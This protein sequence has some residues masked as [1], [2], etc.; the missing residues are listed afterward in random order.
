[1]VCQFTEGGNPEVMQVIDVYIQEIAAE[2]P[3]IL[4]RAYLGIKPW[5]SAD[6]KQRDA[7]LHSSDFDSW[8]TSIFEMRQHL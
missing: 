1:M 8:A 6:D 4:I 5:E 7:T 2:Q 3:R